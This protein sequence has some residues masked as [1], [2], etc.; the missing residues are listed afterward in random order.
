MRFRVSYLR[1]IYWTTS[2]FVHTG[3]FLCQSNGCVVLWSSPG[4]L[5][6]IGV[7]K[8]CPERMWTSIRNKDI[9]ATP[10]LYYNASTVLFIDLLRSYCKRIPCRQQKQMVIQIIETHMKLRQEL[11]ALQLQNYRSLV[12]VKR[13][14]TLLSGWLVPNRVGQETF[15]PSH[16]HSVILGNHPIWY[17]ANQDFLKCAAP[18]WWRQ[19]TATTAK[20]LAV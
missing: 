9:T 19:R 14:P 3:T 18:Y 10:T 6:V 5:S 7:A 1:I 2:Y 12:L 8:W 15:L 4:S 11:L 16:N 17:R 13:K 20:W